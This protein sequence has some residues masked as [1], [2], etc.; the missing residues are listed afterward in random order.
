MSKKPTLLILPPW[1]PS[2]EN[3][4]AGIFFKEQATALKDNFEI[5]IVNCREKT[6]GILLYCIKNIFHLNEVSVNFIENDSG[7]K[8]YDFV[9]EIPKYNQALAKICKNSNFLKFILSPILNCRFEAVKIAYNKNLFEKFDLIYSLSAQNQLSVIAM[10]LSNLFSKPYV[11][12][13]HAPF[14]ILGTTISDNVAKAIENSDAFLA[15]SNDKI[16]QVMMQNI[17]INPY[18][19]GNMIDET[20][21]KL[22]EKK[23]DD[24]KTF[25]IVAANVFYKNYD[26][27]IASMEELKKI[28]DKNFHIIIAGY[29]ANKGYSQNIGI[30][31]N[32][33]ANSS[34]AEN[35]E[36]IG[37]VEREK[38]QDLYQRADIF[39]MTSIQ[40]GLPV[41]AL[42]ASVCGLPVFSTRC[43]GVE[44]YID[45]DMGRIFDILDYKG[46][47]A[48]CRDYLDGKIK[49]DNRLIR[50]KTIKKFGKAA[51]V[52]NLSKIFYKLINGEK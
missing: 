17:K 43:G 42:E 45:D 41:S 4:I 50:E 16:R 13:E 52:E 11:V 25:L 9:Y 3:K 32:K 22:A 46:I 23:E 21:F 12:A 40:E 8:I 38:M 31:E 48:A 49:F 6:I 30:L 10:N 44:D 29:K 7:I 33:I 36:L 34:I 28:T 26:L 37:E 51:F 14:P 27:F 47:A 1:Y 5:M 24:I 39:V 2:K 18:Y 35:V 20:K 15:I 19:I